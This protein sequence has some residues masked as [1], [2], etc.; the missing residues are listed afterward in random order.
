MQTSVILE[1]EHKRA[2]TSIASECFKWKYPTSVSD[3]F[4]LSNKTKMSSTVKIN[5]RE[6]QNIANPAVLSSEDKCIAWAW[7][8]LGNIPALYD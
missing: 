2:Q 8:L 5:V 1:F 7:G 4:D 3:I 6:C